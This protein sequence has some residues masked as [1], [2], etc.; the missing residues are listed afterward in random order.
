MLA[1]ADSNVERIITIGGFMTA[2]PECSQELTQMSRGL[3][4]LMDFMTARLVN[5]QISDSNDE[6]DEETNM[7]FSENE[8][9]GED[10]S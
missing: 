10:F 3:S 5:I 7:S 9:L 1:R 2:R 4:P 6:T 8:T